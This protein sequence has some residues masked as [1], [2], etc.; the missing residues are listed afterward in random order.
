MTERDPEEQVEGEREPP[1]PPI[2][3]D[4]GAFAGDAPPPPLRDP[5]ELAPPPRPGPPEPPPGPTPPRMPH[6]YRRRGPTP[7]HV[8]VFY[9]D[10]G[11]VLGQSIRIYFKNIFT[12]TIVAFLVYL[13]ILACGAIFYQRGE[14]DAE[15]HEVF[16]YFVA[17]ADSLLLTWVLTAA[18]LYG[19]MEQMRGHRPEVGACLRN[20][21]SRIGPVILVALTIVLTYALPMVA[22]VG[23][24]VAGGAPILLLPLGIVW[25]VWFLRLSCTW[26]VALPVC[27]AERPGILASLKRSSA[28]TTRSRWTI[29]GLIIIL[30]VIAAGVSMTVV[31]PITM[32]TAGKGSLAIQFWVMQGVGLFSRSFMAIVPAVVYHELRVGREGADL[33]ELAAV[34]E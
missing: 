7:A 22:F 21:F 14:V 3:P 1:R 20:G 13:P 31:L 15:Q 23:L 17:A 30:W 33:D 26:Y 16:G 6:R 11:K 28:L 34:F 8:R 27:V 2:L 12:F 32:A 9:L 18:L 10:L 4:A 29:L 25:V 24:A 19:V 5:V